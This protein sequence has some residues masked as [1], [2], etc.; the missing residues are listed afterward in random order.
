MGQ[1]HLAVARKIPGAA[2][3]AMDGGGQYIMCHDATL[4]HGPAAHPL[5]LHRPGWS[6]DRLSVLPRRSAASP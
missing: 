3:Q 5:L 2:L 4:L 6:D 1:R